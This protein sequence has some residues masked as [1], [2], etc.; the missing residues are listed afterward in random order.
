ML[1]LWRGGRLHRGICLTR[2]V[3][4]EWVEIPNVLRISWRPVDESFKGLEK[5]DQRREARK[6]LEGNMRR[7]KGAMS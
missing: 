7:R 2:A 4:G 1:L 6:S 5:R 3:S